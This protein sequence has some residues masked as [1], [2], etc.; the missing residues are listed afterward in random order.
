M[1][2]TT[3]LTFLN[4][5][6]PTGL[7]FVIDHGASR[8]VFEMGVEHAPGAMPFGLGLR[9]R[10]GRELLDLLAVGMAP[11]GTGVLGTWDRRSHL[12]LSH[13]HLDHVAL[14]CWVHPEVPMYYPEGMEP[15]REAC[16][17][18]GYL[19]WREPP[20]TAVPDGG[21][22]RVGA[23]EVQFVAVDH[24][25]PGATGFLVR[26]PDLAIAYTG[27]HRWHGLQPG[28]TERFAE[29]V[30]GVGVLV[31]E[32]VS[33]G[34][35]P[36]PEAAP[37]AGPSPE[38]SEEEVI[39]GFGEVLDRAPGLV[40]VNPY[41][42]NRL[43]VHAFG[44]ACAA[45]GR[46]LLMERRSAAMADW[47]LVL[48][49]V[50]AVRDHPD[51]YCVQLDFASL[52]T[53]IDL[54]PPAGSIYVHSNG[55][56]LGPHDPTYQVMLAWMRALDLEFV[57]LG[58][59]GHSRPADILRLVAA[60]RPGVVLPV[61]SRRPEALRAPGVPTLVPEAGRRYTADDLR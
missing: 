47:P 4:L 7:K 58:S 44:A 28:L 23:I 54:G 22:V 16:A 45:R 56:P 26:T 33:L 60:V 1:T 57:T 21:R 27:D 14:A 2:E 30:R 37:G 34:W 41:P 39:Q 53:L 31:Q 10:P 52:P 15:L 38:R 6:S 50:G 25:L 61:H 55:P 18:A 24:D 36:Q 17:R 29:A 19:P 3:G 12:F 35:D 20:G 46:A 43:R 51:R 40:V 59:S 9:P 8:A 48:E 11:H 13:M 42:M 49:D 32:T 5:G